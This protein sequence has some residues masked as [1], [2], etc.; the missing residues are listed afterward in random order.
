[1][2]KFLCVLLLSVAVLAAFVTGCGTSSSEKEASKVMAAVEKIENGDVFVKRASQ[3]DFSK[4]DLKAELFPGDVIR[5]SD[6][7]E[8]VIRFKTGAV[9]RVLPKSD[10]VLKELKF[11]DKEMG[12]VYT[13]LAK[14][15]AYFY[16]P[17][18][19]SEAKKFEVETERA[20][21]SIKGTTFKVADDGNTTTLSVASGVVMFAANSQQKSVDVAA[22]QEAQANSSGLVPVSAGTTEVSNGTGA[23]GETLKQTSSPSDNAKNEPY[24]RKFNFLADPYFSD[25]TLGEVGTK[26]IKGTR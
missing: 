1:M 9:T 17:K 8:A 11:S 5:T 26:V 20:V 4:I 10:F 25:L 22:F 18:G 21:A 15:V 13:K 19:S 2:K 3:N 24:I 7:G 23:P 6:S 12:T 14:G 16:V